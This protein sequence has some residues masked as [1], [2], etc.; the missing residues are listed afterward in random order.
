V[1][2]ATQDPVLR[3]K[4]AGKPEHVVNYFF[5][6][7]E[8]VR[9]IMAQLGIRK[10]D[11]LIG[12]AD[13][14]DTR[15]GIEHWKARGL[16]FSRL[17]AL[18]NV[19]AEVPRFHVEDQD[20]GLHKSLDKVLIE[21]SRAAIDKGEKVQFIEVARNVNRTVGAML[22]GAVT[23]VHPEGLPDDTIRIQLE[24]TGGQSFGAF[25]AR[26]I[27]LYL[28]GD[29]NDYTG[30]GLS[31]GRIVVRPSIDF[32][33]A[34]VENIII[35]NTAL[36][37]ATT[38]EA[39]FS[40]VAGERFAV[41]LSGATAVVE[42]T[43]DHGCEY[44]TGGTVL[45]LG[46]TGRN[47]AAGMSGGIAYVYDEDGRFASRCNTSMVSLEKVG[48]AAEQH[49]GGKTRMHK[50]QADETLLRKLLEDHNRWTG[51]R[52]ARELL[53]TWATSRTK[54][55]KVFPN[56]YKRALAEMYE[57]EVEAASAGTNAHVAMKPEA[58]PAK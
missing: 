27:T 30:K 13:L 38:G 9:Q 14:L 26:G 29:A 57:R 8:E 34:A 50:D 53:D 2:V 49:A 56:E 24:G 35:G 40:G 19:P 22:S 47:F 7:A 52:R 31:G 25:L 5:F 18:P 37:G 42:G 33:G 55:V 39:F 11:E 23:K 58:V 17:F 44:M 32:R 28:I 6:V 41:R 46:K 36:Y 20:H 43:G 21:K 16:D 4:F 45:V 54:F 1:G 15:Q 3:K 10:F 12:R 51:S 48:T